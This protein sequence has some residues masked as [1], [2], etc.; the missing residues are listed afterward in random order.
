M[1]DVASVYLG[2]GGNLGDRRANLRA[3]LAALRPDARLAA[4]S[5][6]YETEP[7]GY[8]EQPEFLNA[9]ARVETTLGPRALLERLKEIERGLGRRERFRNAPRPVDL[10]ILFYDDLTLDEPDLIIP[11]PRLAERAFTLV[12]LVELAPDLRHPWLGRPVSEL[13]DALWEHEA[14]RAIDG[15]DWAA[16]LVTRT[17]D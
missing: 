2:L 13:L 6:L 4:V 12:P 9:V 10:D 7:V 1:R 15:S 16:D 14:I 8:R 11:H 17:E 5:S 3:A